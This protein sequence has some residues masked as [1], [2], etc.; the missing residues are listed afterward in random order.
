MAEHHPKIVIL[1]DEFV[2]N[3]AVADAVLKAA[4]VKRESAMD[5]FVEMQTEFVPDPGHT[6]LNSPAGGFFT[7]DLSDDEAAK[8]AACDEVEAV[9]DDEE[10]FAFAAYDPPRG[11]NEGDLAD[12]IIDLSREEIDQLDKEIQEQLQRPYSDDE[13][14]QQMELMQLTQ[15][16]S[17]GIGGEG[18]AI[19][20]TLRALT[21]Q[22]R[23]GLGVPAEAEPT[24]LAPAFRGIFKFMTE[25]KRPLDEVSDDE[26]ETVLR[27]TGFIEALRSPLARLDLF[28]LNIRMIFAHLAWRLTIGT[29]ARLAIVDTGIAPHPDLRILGGVSFV[30]GVTSWHDDNGHGTH[31]AGT[32]AA[33]LNDR[34]LAGVAPD[35]MLY[36]V[37]VLN[38][39]G[40]G[41]TS[42]VL[43]GLL[44]CY[45]QRMH[46]VNLSL[47]SR[48]TTHDPNVFN[49]VYE[50]Y[51]RLLR[52]RGILPVAAAGNS[53]GPV[54][55]PARCPSY[56]AVSA[57]DYS[58]RRASF[59]NFGPQV[60]ICAPGVNILSTWPGSYNSLSG[61]SM[62]CPHVAGTAALVKSRH[63][64]WHGDV[65]RQRI[66]GTAIDLGAPGTD[67]AFGHGQVNA[68]RAVL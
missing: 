18:A 63:P 33:R 17:G 6:V 24:G 26:I 43:N 41:T 19:E 36:A 52:N 8:V 31:V 39:N 38:R 1:K 54:G 37:K 48:A 11:P 40:S 20:S 59:S 7:V 2:D 27:E 55:N 62:A 42:S 3:P 45:L 9:A 28:P 34:G 29:G 12:P 56:M 10:V 46:V 4:K 60:E 22:A 13:A 5:A 47:G 25:L 49:T 35:A 50:R 68:Y 58:R 44:W 15:P 14:R 53:S 32:A 23:S 67:W 16:P 66:K 57:I 30:P 51:G 21:G 61:T 64:T 65:V